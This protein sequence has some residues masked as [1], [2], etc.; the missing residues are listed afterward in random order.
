MDLLNRHNLNKQ[1]I[2]FAAAA[3]I[4]GWVKRDIGTTFVGF[5]DLK[6]PRQS[7]SASISANP[8]KSIV[9]F[10]LNPTYELPL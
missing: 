5:A 6:A 10:R 1:G 8:T 9:D 4:V 3:H 2:R 7:E